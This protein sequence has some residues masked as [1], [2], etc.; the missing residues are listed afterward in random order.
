MVNWPAQFKQNWTKFSRVSY[1]HVSSMVPHDTSSYPTKAGLADNGSHV[2][3]AMPDTLKD[4]KGQ[5][6]QSYGS[7][8]DPG[9]HHPGIHYTKGER[10]KR[11]T[12]K[13]MF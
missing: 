5:I 6:L 9:F 1:S 12:V 11:R 3:K 8:F 10:D 2:K 7:N 13:N 4:P